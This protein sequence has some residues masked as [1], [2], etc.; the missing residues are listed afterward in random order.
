MCRRGDR[1]GRLGLR[2]GLGRLFLRGGVCGARWRRSGE[3]RRR[4][5]R[6]SGGDRR[7]HAGVARGCIARGSAHPVEAER[8][9][10]ALLSLVAPRCG[11]RVQPRLHG[12]LDVFRHLGRL[13]RGIVQARRHVDG[14]GLLSCV[15]AVR[16]QID[17]LRLLCQ[18]AHRG[19]DVEV[20]DVKTAAPSPAPTVALRGGILALAG[21][22]ARFATRGGPR[23]IV[24]T[25][26]RRSSFEPLR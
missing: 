5:R 3:T 13:L 26:E 17:L 2:L 21:H 11:V 8:G 6:G 9:T 12:R 23:R 20:T 4:R 19:G 7:G 16:L 18:R 15:R 10:L 25:A 14:V 22:R 24:P 1:R